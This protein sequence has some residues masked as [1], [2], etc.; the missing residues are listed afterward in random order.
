MFLVCLNFCF[1]LP[2]LVCADTFLHEGVRIGI[3]Q[4]VEL[5]PRGHRDHEGLFQKLLSC[6]V[7]SY[8]L[9]EPFHV[10]SEVLHVCHSR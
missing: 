4:E 10:C 3:E 9:H 1:N 5:S 8:A 7:A 2:L 6:A